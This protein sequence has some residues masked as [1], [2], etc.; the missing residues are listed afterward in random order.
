MKLVSRVLS[1]L[2]AGVFLICQTATGADYAGGRALARLPNETIRLDS[3]QVIF[4]LRP[5]SYTVESDFHFFNTGEATTEWLYFPAASRKDCPPFSDFMWFDTKIEGGKASFSEDRDFFKNAGD[6]SQ[7]V[8]GFTPDTEPKGRVML[9]TFPGHAVTTLHVSYEARYKGDRSD[10]G[11]HVAFLNMEA[12]RYWK[13]KIRKSV[14]IVDAS[15]LYG[16]MAS[17]GQFLTEP[18][19]RKIGDSVERHETVDVDPRDGVGF[20]TSW[21]HSYPRGRPRPAN[22]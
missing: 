14:M 22:Q 19:S 10:R 8:A 20:R 17:R 18:G 13:D 11:A 2:I 6:D 21:H 3:A 7:Y 1:S 16:T 4:R 9:V 15:G 12:R 5:S